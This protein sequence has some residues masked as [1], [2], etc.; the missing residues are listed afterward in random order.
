MLSIVGSHR[1]LFL[2]QLPIATLAVALL[3]WRVDILEGLRSLSDVQLGWV[4]AGLVTFT[5]SKAV[6]AYRWRVLLQ[7]RQAP[8]APLLGIFFVSNL[9]NA[10]VPFRAGDL[11]RIELPSRLLRLPRAELASNVLVVETIFDGLAFVLLAVAAGALL[12]DAVVALPALLAFVTLV[13]LAFAGLTAVARLRIPEDPSD[14]ALLRWLPARWREPGGRLARQFIEGMTSL[15]KGRRVAG[16]LLVSVAAWMAEVVVYWMMGQAFGVEL[17]IGEAIVLML[18][19][20]LVV[21][22]P[23]TPWDVGPYELA[24][25]EAFVLL[26]ADRSEA[27]SY[28]VGSHVLLIA[29]IT[30]SGLLAMLALSLRPGE[31]LRRSEE[32]AAEPSRDG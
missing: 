9:A 32:P 6:H 28:A 24:V 10:I 7:H 27:S 23:I 2:A 26:G 8:L 16:A 29:W 22:L 25:T 13:L 11:I 15:R 21:S 31:L 3:I 18:A 5:A 1:R 30:V 17:E 12:G 19:A 14:S 4:A 20:N